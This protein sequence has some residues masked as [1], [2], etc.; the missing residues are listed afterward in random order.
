MFQNS[1]LDSFQLIVG[2]YLI[3]VA[4]KGSGQMYRFE[5][6]PAEQQDSVRKKLRIFYAAAAAVALADFG[7]SYLMNTMFTVSADGGE[8]IVTQNYTLPQL[9]FLTYDLLFAVSNVLSVLLIAMLLFAVI[10]LGR[11]GNR[12]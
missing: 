8:R 12:S 1:L 6:V 3:Y 5:N 9:P 4:I 10:R 11:S 7:V 2:L